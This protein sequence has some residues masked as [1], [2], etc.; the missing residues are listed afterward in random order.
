MVHISVITPTYNTHP[1]VLARTWASLKA[2]TFTDWEWVVWDDSTNSDVWNQVY[3]FASDE[4]Y[5]LRAF[6]SHVHS[7]VIG[8]VK[9]WGF[10][11]AEGEVLVELDH[12]DELT[13]DAL[14]EIAKAFEGRVDFVFS[15][16]CELFADGTSGKYPEGWGLGNGREYWD[17]NI[18]AWGLSIPIMNDESIKHIVGV[19]NH[20]RAWRADFYREI[21]GHDPTLDVCDDYELILRTYENGNWDHIPKVLYK[22]H[23]GQTTQRKKNARI[24]ELVPIIYDKY[25]LLK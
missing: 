9:R 25:S 10:M 1:D 3:G 17:E 11:V 24:Q 2:Q 13:P 18:G 14:A 23:I 7:G 19:P 4:R 5:K 6:K 21:G 16:W 22:Q 12:D 8:Q 15:D 20:V